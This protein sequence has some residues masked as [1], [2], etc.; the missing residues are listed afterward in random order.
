[1]AAVDSFNAY[2]DTLSGE[3]RE[4]FGGKPASI[5][6]YERCFRCGSPS[7]DFVPAKQTDRPMAVTL[8]AVIAPNV[9][10]GRNSDGD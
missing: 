9:G 1:M 8:Q 2:F 10:T 6:R 7:K 3:K 5:E 4:S